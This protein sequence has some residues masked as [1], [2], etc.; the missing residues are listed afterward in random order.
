MKYLTLSLIFWSTWTFGQP[1]DTCRSGWAYEPYQECPNPSGGPDTSSP[2]NIT[3]SQRDVVAWKAPLTSSDIDRQ[4]ATYCQD[5]VN[6]YNQN[7]A[8]LAAGKVAALEAGT[9]FRQ[10][11]NVGSAQFPRYY[12]FCDV[13]INTYFL[14]KSPSP[15]CGPTRAWTIVR[16]IQPAPQ[17]GKNIRCLSCDNAELGNLPVQESVQCL[18]ANVTAV[19]K[20]LYSIEESDAAAMATTYQRL[21][22]VGALTNITM[23]QVNTFAAFWSMVKQKYPNVSTP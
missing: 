4:P 14:K 13:T 19:V 11:P 16:G 9:Q 12:L 7:P 8:N 21:L 17:S 23:N 18:G 10:G 22:Q 5:R 20:G 15:S 3:S 1:T 2:Q 6:E